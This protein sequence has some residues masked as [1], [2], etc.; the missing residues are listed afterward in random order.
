MIKKNQPNPLNFFS[1][2]RLDF[3]PEY[4]DYVDVGMQ[5]NIEDS[6][7]RWIES[8]LKGRFY[9]GRSVKTDA[10]NSIVTYIQVGFEDPKESSYFTLAC[11]Y[12]K[13]T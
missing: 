5:Y 6:I 13:Y 12:L 4:F 7:V 10:N 3:P 9:A 2:R 8:N 11:P 1:L